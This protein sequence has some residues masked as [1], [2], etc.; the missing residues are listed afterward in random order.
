MCHSTIVNHC[1]FMGTH[2]EFWGRGTEPLRKT[3][4]ATIERCCPSSKNIC[5]KAYK[6]SLKQYFVKRFE[7]L[8]PLLICPHSSPPPL[9]FF[10]FS[11]QAILGE[12]FSTK[13]TH[14]TEM[15]NTT[16]THVATCCGAGIDATNAH[17][18]V[19][20]QSEGP[21]D[22]VASNGIL[23]IQWYS[24]IESLGLYTGRLLGSGSYVRYD[25][26]RWVCREVIL[27]VRERLLGLI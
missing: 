24:I 12:Y 10:F 11:G 9:R 6:D 4:E 7:C 19:T 8:C 26:L 21:M 13:Y 20:E 22:T 1:F 23:N 25:W 14:T 2:K 15:K 27:R 16:R 3:W 5:R 18:S 17:F